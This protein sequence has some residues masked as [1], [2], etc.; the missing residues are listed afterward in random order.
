METET[1][2]FRLERRSGVI[3]MPGRAER[4]DCS[5]EKN[6]TLGD[7]QSL[8]KTL[9]DKSEKLNTALKDLEAQL[10]AVRLGKDVWLASDPLNSKQLP[11]AEGAVKTFLGLARI[12]DSVRLAVREIT[13]LRKKPKLDAFQKFTTPVLRFTKNGTNWWGVAGPPRPLLGA[14]RELR[15]QALEWKQALIDAVAKEAEKVIAGFN[16]V[17]P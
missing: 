7:L 16:R 13:Y 2:P 1:R 11:D 3:T 6:Y 4:G 5:M 8:S 10:S 15:L 14:S 9:N 12:D 17:G